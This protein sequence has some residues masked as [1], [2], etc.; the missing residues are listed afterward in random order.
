MP[1]KTNDKLQWN[2]SWN[3]YQSLSDALGQRYSKYLWYQ[4]WPNRGNT[5]TAVSDSTAVTTPVVGTLA[6]D[7]TTVATT[8]VNTSTSDSTTVT[9]APE[10]EDMADGTSY[11]VKKNDT[12]WDIAKNELKKNSE[13]V[14]NKQILQYVQQIVN[15]NN[16]HNG[17]LIYVDNVLTLPEFDSNTPAYQPPQSKSSKKKKEEGS[18]QFI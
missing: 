12:L 4:A 16:I 13:K 18:L 10:E 14:S 17:E 2:P 1:D 5:N 7:T 15:Q 6:S 9:T 3:P 11:K 8:P